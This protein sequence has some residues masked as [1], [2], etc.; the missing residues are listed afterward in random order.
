[1]ESTEIVA[2]YQVS[3][4]TSFLFF[5]EVKSLKFPVPSKMTCYLLQ[6]ST[7]ELYFLFELF[8]D[9]FHVSGKNSLFMNF[10]STHSNNIH[11]LEQLR[12]NENKAS[13]FSQ[14]KYHH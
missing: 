13:S 8:G 7:D 10:I 3:V 4:I 6:N 11:A 14:V 12:S 2:F 5:H 9:H 1:M